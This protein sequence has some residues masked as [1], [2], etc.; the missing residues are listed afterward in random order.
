MVG[1]LTLQYSEDNKVELE[2]SQLYKL[3]MID[4]G[5]VARYRDNNG[6]HIKQGSTD[7][8]KGSMLFASKNA[9]KFELCSR[10][11]DLISLVYTLVFMLDQSRMSFI[12]NLVD[13]DK[14]E[15]LRIVGE[16]KDKMTVQDLCGSSESE[17]IAFLLTPFAEEVMKYEYDEQ[18]DYNKLRFL[19]ERVLM[20]KNIAPSRK[21]DWTPERK[22]NEKS[23]QQARDKKQALLRQN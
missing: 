12:N 2:L 8:F 1:N 22:Q 23:K 3:Y 10:R 13:K 18:P 9:F 20:Q 4:F 15:R 5:L 19:L 6:S 14:L 16:A 21:Y 11:D 7:I 17:S